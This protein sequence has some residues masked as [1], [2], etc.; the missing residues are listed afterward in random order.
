MAGTSLFLRYLDSQLTAWS[1]PMA[2]MIVSGT[3]MT[4]ILVMVKLTSAAPVGA[5]RSA[6]SKTRDEGD[7]MCHE[8]LTKP[9]MKNGKVKSGTAAISFIW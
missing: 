2:M 6:A 3:M 9:I 4:K 5:A 1:K 8:S 7:L